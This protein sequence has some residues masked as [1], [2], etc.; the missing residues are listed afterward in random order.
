MSFLTQFSQ[1]YLTDGHKTPGEDSTNNCVIEEATRAG[2]T[3]TVK[4]HR[5]TNTGD[6]KDVPIKVQFVLTL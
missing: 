3:T 2:G 1:D 4:Y 6:S 5:K